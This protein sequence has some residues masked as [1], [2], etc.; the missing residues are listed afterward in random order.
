MLLYRLAALGKCQKLCRKVHR[1]MQGLLCLLKHGE[2]ML[3]LI[4][5]Q[6][7]HG[8]ITEDPLQQVVEIVAI[9]PAR[10]PMASSFCVLSC[11]FKEVFLVMLLIV[12][13]TD[14]TAPEASFIG[15][16][17]VS[18]YKIEP[19]A[20]ECLCSAD[21]G[22]LFKDQSDSAFFTFFIA[23]SGSFMRYLVAVLADD[24]VA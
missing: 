18:T 10:V 1:H 4:K 15:K 6:L 19:L 17:F 7:C 16:A 13:I 3:L 24:R 11:F 8:Y 5:G 22:S 2:T 14:V 23:W 12:S 20:S 9:P 21:W